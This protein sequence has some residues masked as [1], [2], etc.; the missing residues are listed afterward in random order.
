MGGGAVHDGGAQAGDMYPVQGVRVAGAVKVLHLLPPFLGGL[1]DAAHHGGLARPGAPLE[2]DE[3][4]EVLRR[5]ELGEEVLKSQA[6]VGPQ[7]KV[8]GAVH[9]FSS[10]FLDSQPR[11]CGKRAW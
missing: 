2:D 1:A 5:A 10:R 9:E 8:C 7:E 11:I 4:I 3:V 6:A